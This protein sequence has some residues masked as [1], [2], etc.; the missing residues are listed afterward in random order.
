MGKLITFYSLKG[1]SGKSTL[2][3]MTG[4]ALSYN[5]KSFAIVNMDNQDCTDYL[6]HVNNLGIKVN[7]FTEQYSKETLNNI[8][9]NYDIVF[10]DLPPEASEALSFFDLVLIPTNGHKS[11]EL[12]TE[13]LIRQLNEFNVANRVVLYMADKVDPW[14]NK[15]NHLKTVYYKDINYIRNPIKDFKSFTI[16]NYDDL[17]NQLLKEIKAL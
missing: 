1:G 7:Y 12:T 4:M 13:K 2:T 16:G 17:T 14:I 15:V 8:K 5:S 9:D 3:I 11:Q 6:N 10:V